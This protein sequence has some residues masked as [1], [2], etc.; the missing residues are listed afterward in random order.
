MNEFTRR[1][2]LQGGT[3]LAAA[4]ALTGPALLDFA[5]AWAQTAPWKAGAGRQAHRDA[6]EALRAGRRRRLQRH[7]RRLQDRDRHRDERVQRIL[8]GR[9]AEGLGRRQH[10]LGPRSR[11]GPAHAAAA[12]P[13][14]GAE[15]ERR[16]RLSRQEIRRLDRR[17]AEDLQAGQRLARHSRRD[18]RRLH[19][20][21]QVGDREGRLQGI[22]EGFPGLPRTVQGAEGEQHAGRLRARPRLRRRQRLAALDPVG[23]RRLHRRQGRQGHHQLAG[24]RE[25]A[26]ILSRRCPTPSFPAS[27][28][29]TTRPTTRR[30]WR[31]NCTAPPTASRSTSR[32]RT[33]RPRRSSPRTPITRCGR[34]A[35]SA[36]RP[37]C[38]SAFRS[39]RSTSPSIR[40]PRRPSSPSCWRRRTSTSGCRARGA[41]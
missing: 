41:I 7:G 15:D 29:G 6:L 24:D 16:R 25:G 5:K 9:A 30:S 32:P 38:S 31:A 2:L 36:S 35:R 39:W 18:H 27:R 14:Q 28:R 40:T 11:L 20:L 22:P 17:G 4:G 3:A 13:D 12:V 21:P 1:S 8:R 10:R 23:P 33:I 34:S 19:D 26:G 37:N